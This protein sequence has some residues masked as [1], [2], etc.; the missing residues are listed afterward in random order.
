MYNDSINIRLT[1]DSM[2][3][4][5]DKNGLTEQEFLASYHAGDYPR[6]SMAVDMVIFT[7]A[8]KKSDNYRKLPEK[9]LQLLL[10]QRGGHPYL[11]S[12]AL[13]GGFVEPDETTEQAAARELKEETGISD[14]YLEQLY[15]FSEPMRDPRTWVMS[16]SYLALA[17]RSKLKIQAGDDADRTDWF[18]ISFSEESQSASSVNGV[19]ERTTIYQL[20][21]TNGSTTLHSRV[22]RTYRRSENGSE[23]V[24]D[25]LDRGNLAFDHAKII[26]AA[27]IRL[28][29]KVEYTD[30]ALNLVPEYF[31]LTE[32]QQVY[33]I[34]LGKP[35]IKA[36]FRRKYAYLTDPT[37]M[38]TSDAGHRPSKLYRR[39]W[40]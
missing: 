31:T 5:R 28:R 10:I 12:W 36:P 6:P 30:I 11:G 40:M 2:E 19:F 23:T 14:I 3:Q 34:I 1:G 24:F 9:E 39:K 37:D 21:L 38:L 7:A 29:G 35:L 20:Q 25:I 18:T 27:I 33:E 15:T 32:L 22:S 26:T 16:C 17:D 4:L 13:P 8:E